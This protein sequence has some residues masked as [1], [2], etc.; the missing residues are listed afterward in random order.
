MDT[1]RV[2]DAERRQYGIRTLS[3]IRAYLT[4]QNGEDR[5]WLELPDSI[6]VTIR[7]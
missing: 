7:G 6:K 3:E 4:Q 2:S 1:T 5:G